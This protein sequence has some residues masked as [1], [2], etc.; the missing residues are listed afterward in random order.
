MLDANL[1]RAWTLSMAIALRVAAA[2]EGGRWGD[3][4]VLKTTFAMGRY[5]DDDEVSNDYWFSLCL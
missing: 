4:A 5:A 2:I 3:R 1:R